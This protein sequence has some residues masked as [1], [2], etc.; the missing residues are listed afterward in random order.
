MVNEDDILLV[1]GGFSMDASQNSLAEHVSHMVD[2]SD[3]PDGCSQLDSASMDPRM[4]IGT[5]SLSYAV[6]A[7]FCDFYT[8]RRC[9]FVMM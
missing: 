6:V 1:S 9:V 4:R 2:G 5:I 3:Q 8:P 7:K